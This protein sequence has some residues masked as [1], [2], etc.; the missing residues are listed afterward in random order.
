MLGEVEA[1]EVATGEDSE[2]AVRQGEEV[3]HQVGEDREASAAVVRGE[4]DST[5]EDV[6]VLHAREVE[7][8]KPVPT[9]KL[10]TGKIRWARL[11]SR[12]TTPM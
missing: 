5:V 11:R 3:D 1:A 10:K 4:V 12:Q 8:T 7:A 6:V 2:D 9:R